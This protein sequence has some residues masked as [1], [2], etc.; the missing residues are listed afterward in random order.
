M[1]CSQHQ[2][3]SI[4]FDLDG[5]LINTAPDVRLALNHMLAC[6]G[7]PG[8]ELDELY[9]MIG[10][11][12]R[13]MVKNALCNHDLVLSET[14]IDAAVQCYL[15]YYRAHPVVET[16]I[17]P[18][19]IQ[20]LAL[21][22]NDGIQMGICTNKPS[23]M[24]HIVLEVLQLRDYFVA[25]VAGDEVAKPKPHHLH[26]MAVLQRMQM[27]E[28]HTLLVGDSEI[29]QQCA[30]NARVP[31]VGV[32]YGYHLEQPAPHMID[33]FSELPAILTTIPSRG[34]LTL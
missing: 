29:D 21:L 34:L 22:K 7:Q 28:Q 27:S 5:T 12:A 32:R 18:G 16:T 6:Y 8:I 3:Q 30:E 4:I 1:L 19:V 31:F 20:T 2:F 33:H 14:E 11:G 9:T 15:N 10:T 23:V 25:V 13:S 24:T 17:Y 26:L